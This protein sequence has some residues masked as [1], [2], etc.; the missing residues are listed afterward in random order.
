[1]LLPSLSSLIWVFVY[2][3]YAKSVEYFPGAAPRYRRDH[4]ALPSSLIDK[5]KPVPLAARV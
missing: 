2:L 5:K 1:M 4:T 3:V